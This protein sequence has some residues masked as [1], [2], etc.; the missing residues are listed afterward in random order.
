MK[1]TKVRLYG[2]ELECWYVEDEKG[3]KILKQIEFEYKEYDIETGDLVGYGSEDFSKERYLKTLLTKTAWIWDG[4]KRNAGG[5]RWFDMGR[6]VKYCKGKGKEVKRYL[7][8][9]Y[10]R[11]CN[12]QIVEMR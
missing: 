8:N 5:H 2:R 4:F 9:Y 3:R 1:D 10:K 12:A 11:V 7:E 6:T